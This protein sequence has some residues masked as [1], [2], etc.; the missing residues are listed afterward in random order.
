MLGNVFGMLESTDDLVAYGSAGLV[1]AA[2][3]G[4]FISVVDLNPEDL[5]STGI[6]AAGTVGGAYMV[7]NKNVF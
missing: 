4:W 2:L 5:I 6:M 7:Y 3:S 1:G